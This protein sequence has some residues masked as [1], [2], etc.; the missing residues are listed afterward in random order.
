LPYVNDDDSLNMKSILYTVFIP[1]LL[2]LN[3]RGFFYNPVKQNKNNTK[4]AMTFQLM[5]FYIKKLP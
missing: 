1:Q 2:H 5:N 4:C 3:Q